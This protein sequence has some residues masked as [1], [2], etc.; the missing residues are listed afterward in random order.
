M[1][2][3]WLSRCDEWRWQVGERAVE[4]SRAEERVERG[5]KAR[6]RRAHQV[7]PKAILGSLRALR[8]CLPA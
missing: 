4:Q 6:D 5:R 8:A 1:K 2:E 7:P 3:R